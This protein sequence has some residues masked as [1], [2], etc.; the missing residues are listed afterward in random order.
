[1]QFCYHPDGEW[2]SWIDAQ[3]KLIKMQV[4]DI[5]DA[6]YFSKAPAKEGDIHLK[7]VSFLLKK[8]HISKSWSI[9]NEVF[10]KI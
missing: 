3:G 4:V 6:C 7:F 9:L 10:L 8:N 5:M 1:M 2:E